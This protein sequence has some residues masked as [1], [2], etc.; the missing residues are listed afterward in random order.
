MEQKKI[1]RILAKASEGANRYPVEDILARFGVEYRIRGTQAWFICPVCGK[2]KYDYCSATIQGIGMGKWCCQSCKTGGGTFRLYSL[3]S[4]QSETDSL[5][6]LGV[7][8]G[9]VTNDEYEE[10]TGS[11][12]SR[13]KLR[14]DE[15]VRKKIE[16]KKA[17]ETVE[18]KAPIKTVDF[19]Y[20][21]LLSLPQF[22]LTDEARDYLRSRR[23]S[24][25]EITELG[26]FSYKEN[27]SVKRF[28]DTLSKSLYGKG[29]A[30]LD[31]ERKTGLYNSLWGIPG[32]YFEY[33]NSE[34]NTGTWK[35]IS[36]IPDCVGI[37]IKNSEGH[38][39]ALQMRWLDGEKDNK[40]FY[41][42]SRKY[43][44]N[45]AKHTN[46]GSSPGSPVAALYPEKVIGQTFYVTEGLFKAKELSRSG[47]VCYSV[48]GVN[49]F[50]YV[51]DEIK[52]TL[53]SDEFRKRGGNSAKRVALAFDADMYSKWQVL[54]AAV[55]ASANI[56]RKT[57]METYILLWDP[58]LGK[59]YDDYKFL[60]EDKGYNYC[61]GLRTID[62]RRFAD[63]AKEASQDADKCFSHQ[64]GKSPE[65]ADRTGTEWS[66]YL[67]WYL[68]EQRI[69]PMFGF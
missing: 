33:N 34:K 44:Q 12:D 38:I 63:I 66:G 21:N 57:Q 54:D 8:S 27:F 40:Y 49:S 23:L 52:E 24:D 48:Q 37:P 68:F 47:N 43:H 39:S 69:K 51:A 56:S 25:K 31:P 50:Y 45:E 65:P 11:E 55:K 22:Q 1:N 32:F 13:T 26:F 9:M 53:D 60:C 17:S 59:G 16:E 61:S 15:N 58:S 28:M 67:H 62:W 6:A 10:A 64:H 4:G 14:A 35:F 18:R 2:P 46:F 7:L 5:L 20:R 3:L 41:V 42:S 19:V 29:I 36:P 30:E